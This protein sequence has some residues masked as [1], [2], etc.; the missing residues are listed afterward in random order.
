MVTAMMI[1][2]CRWNITLSHHIHIADR[3]S[4]CQALSLQVNLS[5]VLSYTQ[6]VGAQIRPPAASL[7]DTLLFGS[8]VVVGDVNG[9]TFIDFTINEIGNTTLV[10][11]NANLYNSAN[12]GPNNVFSLDTLDHVVFARFYQPTQSPIAK[13]SRPGEFADLNGDGLADMVWMGKTDSDAFV[14]DVFVL[15]GRTDWGASGRTLTLEDVATFMYSM[16]A[17]CAQDGDLQ[18]PFLFGDDLMY[19]DFDADGSTDFLIAA[20][21]RDFGSIPQGMVVFGS[22]DLFLDPIRFSSNNGGDHE[23]W[24]TSYNGALHDANRGT[25]TVAAFQVPV[26]DE[27]FE[28]GDTEHIVPVTLDIVG[29]FDIS[30]GG[31]E[32][33]TLNSVWPSLNSFTD[34]GPADSV[35]AAAAHF[36]DDIEFDFSGGSEPCDTDPAGSNMPYLFE[37]YSNCTISVAHTYPFAVIGRESVKLNYLLYTAYSGKAQSI[38]LTYPRRF[39]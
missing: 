2:W 27:D 7:R 30:R 35:T 15:S 17:F 34:F 20:L 19:G 8:P 3:R 31:V 28:C 11:G 25:Q 22:S 38:T 6:L 21:K 26:S 9:D 10:F 39:I 5:T 37:D 16:P 1:C 14:S 12:W 32:I 18:G 13:S 36:Y 29:D 24:F 4:S 33:W 23:L